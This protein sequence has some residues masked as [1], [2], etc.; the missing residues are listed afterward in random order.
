MVHQA[1]ILIQNLKP[2]AICPNST[3]SCL[4][5]CHQSLPLSTYTSAITGSKPRLKYSSKPPTL[6][7]GRSIPLHL[8]DACKSQLPSHLENP[9]PKGI[10]LPFHWVYKEFCTLLGDLL[11]IGPNQ[12]TEHEGSS[13]NYVL[14]S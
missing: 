8:L 11:I 10:D 3:S 4:T 2:L 12:G 13:L 6:L 9:I 7:Y 5:I 1:Q 14:S